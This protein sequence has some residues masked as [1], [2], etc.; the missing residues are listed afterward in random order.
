M[1]RQNTS[2]FPRVIPEGRPLCCECQ[3][4][5][6]VASAGHTTSAGD[7]S[8]PASEAVA[9]AAAAASSSRS[10]GVLPPELGA[11]VPFPLAELPSANRGFSVMPF[12]AS[13]L[14]ASS[15]HAR[16]PFLQNIYASDVVMVAKLMPVRRTSLYRRK[17]LSG[18][19]VLLRLS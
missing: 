10:A 1:P 16:E 11:E 5:G 12:S 15:L 4:V 18:H 3:R 7:S 9:G 6:W 19:S 14:L 2:E 13:S 8:L 17:V